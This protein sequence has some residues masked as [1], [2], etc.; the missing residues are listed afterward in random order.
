MS[1]TAIPE[2]AARARTLAAAYMS[3]LASVASDLSGEEAVRGGATPTAGERLVFLKRRMVVKY[4]GA[5]AERLTSS[6]YKKWR[7]LKQIGGEGV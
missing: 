5:D 4:F 3:K 2:L 7:G 6:M 1:V